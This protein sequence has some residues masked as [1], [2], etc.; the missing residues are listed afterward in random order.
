MRRRRG[1]HPA[2][3]VDLLQLGRDP[4]QLSSGRSDVPRKPLG[5]CKIYTRL[6]AQSHRDCTNK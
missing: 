3:L 5:R 1:E 4:A 6:M 2:L